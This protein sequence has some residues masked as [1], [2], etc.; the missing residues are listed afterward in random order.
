MTRNKQLCSSLHYRITSF[1]N[2]AKT[3][4]SV[5]LPVGRQNTRHGVDFER[6]INIARVNIITNVTVSA[7][8]FV[9]SFDLQSIDV[10]NV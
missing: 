2:L 10:R 8:V 1:T 3:Y 5:Q 6:A 9:E 7:R 4:F